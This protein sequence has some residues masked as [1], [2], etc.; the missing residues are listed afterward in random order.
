LAV[1]GQAPAALVPARVFSARPGSWSDVGWGSLAIASAFGLALWMSGFTID[2]ALISVRYARHLAE[3][4]GYRFNTDGPCTDGVTPLPWPFLLAP[5]AHAPALVVLA[6]ARALGLGTWIAAAGGWG[7]AVGR[8]PAPIQAKLAAMALLAACLPVA[9]HAVSGMETGVAISLA[10]AAVI[11]NNPWTCCT[12]AGLAASLR[13]EMAVWSVV[14]AV[15]LGPVR[16]AIPHALIAATPFIACA[17]VRVVAFGR[18]APLAVLAKPSDLAHGLVYASASA[19]VSI[20]PIVVFAPLALRREW[21][22]STAI[23][24]AGVAHFAAI[25]AVGGDWM[26]YARLAAPVIPSLL[27]AFVLASPRMSRRF[28]LVRVA[29]AMGIAVYVLVHAAP[30]GRHV[31]SHAA[32]LVKAARPELAGVRR[33]AA[34]DVGW[35]TAASEASI[36]DLAGLTDPEIAAL[37]GGHTS[38]RIDAAFLLARDP[39]VLLLYWRRIDG[40]RVYWR[41]VEARL[42]SSELIGRHYEARAFLPSY[43]EDDAGYTVFERR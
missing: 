19:I 16:R 24:L 8:S 33:I 22:R 12:L 25:V 11:A 27:Y 15:A 29:L 1:I 17:V 20:G 21:D 38:K 6:R 40:E 9:A 18:A 36:V 4:E 43:G 23:V 26:P 42:A 39:D 3:G 7:I 41:E 14:L 32:A 31:E 28:G 34:L 2:D 10:T 35:P 5:F 30:A 13:P 37:P